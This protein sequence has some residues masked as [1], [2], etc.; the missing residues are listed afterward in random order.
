MAKKKLLWLGDAVASTG[1]ARSTHRILEAFSLEEYEIAVVGINYWG[2]PHR[3][4]YDIYPCLINSDPFG[5]QRVEKLANQ[6][7]PD[8]IV[9]QH[10]HWNFKAYFDVIPNHIPIVGIVPVDG[11][12]M[13]Y[14]T[15]L[16]RLTDAIFWCQFGQDEAKRCGYVGNST[17]IPLGVD[18][19]IYWPRGRRASRRAYGIPD[20]AFIVGSVARNNPRKRLDLTIEYVAEFIRRQRRDDIYLFMHCTDL[21]TNGWNIKELARMWEIEGRVFRTSLDSYLGVSEDQLAEI[22]STFDVQLST[23]H[24][25]GFGLPVLEGMACGVPQVVPDWSA[26]GDWP[27]DGAI[28]VPC[29]QHTVIPA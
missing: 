2:D 16:N 28:K 7:C 17:V 5:I 1:F 23:A 8:V 26:L 4:P 12:H 27:R 18:L 10:D 20:D 11:K 24:G 6:W 14:A 13:Q 29:S 9:I 25:E 21:T 3:Y 15:G 19:E 22:Y